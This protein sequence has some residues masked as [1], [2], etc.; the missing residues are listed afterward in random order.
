MY[1][2][3]FIGPLHYLYVTHQRGAQNSTKM[4]KSFY[5]VHDTVKYLLS[6]LVLHCLTLFLLHL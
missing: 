1:Y 6:G 3:A 2:V 4:E 5:W